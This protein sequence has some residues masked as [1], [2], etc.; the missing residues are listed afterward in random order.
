MMFRVHL[1]FETNPLFHYDFS[2]HRSL[3]LDIERNMVNLVFSSSIQEDSQYYKIC[4]MNY[5][6]R[7]FIYLQ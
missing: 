1:E 5:F 6:Y 4:Y 7:Q 2:I 3:L